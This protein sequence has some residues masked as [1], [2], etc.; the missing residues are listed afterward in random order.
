MKKAL[1]MMIVL[2]TISA[3]AQER[4]LRKHNDDRMTNFKEFSPEEIAQLK[5]KKLTLV[6]D[7]TEVQKKKIEAIEFEKVQARK[8]KF[9]S[10]K[11]KT[12]EEVHKKPSKEERLERMNKRLDTQI[13]EKAAMKD[14]LNEDQFKKWEK[15]QARKHLNNK[16]KRGHGKKHKR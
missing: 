13:V 10:R 5:T 15:L 12:L 8:L 11:E 9:A 14:L 3:T 1:M 16:H 7:L 2:I 4:G 6:L